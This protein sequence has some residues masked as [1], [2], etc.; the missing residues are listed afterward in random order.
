MKRLV[1]VV[2]TIIATASGA[3]FARAEPGDTRPEFQPRPRVNFEDKVLEVTKAKTGSAFIYFVAVQGAGN[4]S[5]VNLGILGP[6]DIA[7]K[8]FAAYPLVDGVFRGLLVGPPGDYRVMWVKCSGFGG[9]VLV[10]P[11]A[12]FRAAAGEF[13]NVGLLR[14]EYTSDGNI[15]FSTG[16]LKKG[17]EAPS[18]AAL[19]AVKSKLPKLPPAVSRPMTML[20]PAEARVKGR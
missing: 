4:C 13:V 16:T 5:T 12:T 6:T 8:G 10:G 1:F 2:L 7:A 9:K 20:G 17:V 15:F 3:A 19:A 14:L 18:A 11:H